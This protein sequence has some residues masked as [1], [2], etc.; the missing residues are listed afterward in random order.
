[1]LETVERETLPS[2]GTVMFGLGVGEV[3]ALLLLG[4]LFEVVLFWASASLG[5]APDTNLGKCLLAGRL[6]FALFLPAAWLVAYLS[7]LVGLGFA[8]EPWV[9][10]VLAPASSEKVNTRRMRSAGMSRRE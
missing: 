7:R 3:T 4:C 10:A 1:M 6:V 8:N 2:E 5:D 9:A